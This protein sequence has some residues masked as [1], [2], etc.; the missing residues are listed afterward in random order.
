MRGICLALFAAATLSAQK[1]PS[2]SEINS[3]LDKILKILEEADAQPTPSPERLKVN[4]KDLPSIGSDSAPL[5]LVEFTDFQ[6]PFCA[7]FH[8][9][10]FPKIRDAYVSTGKLRFMH[11]DLPLAMHDHAVIAAQAGRCAGDQKQF[12]QM[13]EW[14]GNNPQ[15]LEPDKIVAEAIRLNLD[16]EKFRWCLSTG[17]YKEAVELEARDAMDTLQLRGTPAFLLG[18]T[19]DIVDGEV[20]MGSIPYAKFEEKFKELMK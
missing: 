18:K 16:V 11:R 1:P 8:Q 5:T 10:V 20:I 9:D 2:L 7:Q 6:C 12:W 19:A 15:E 13:R 3:K 4:V 17:K 14:L